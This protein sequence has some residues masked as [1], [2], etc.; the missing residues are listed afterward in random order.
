MARNYLVDVRIQPIHWVDLWLLVDE[1]T[2]PS[3]VEVFNV[4][5]WLARLGV[6][7]H[8]K[9][10]ELDWR[11]CVSTRRSHNAQ[12]K[13]HPRTRA[14]R[15]AEQGCGAPK[16][17]S[18]ERAARR[19]ESDLE[20]RRRTEGRTST[21][22]RSVSDPNAATAVFGESASNDKRATV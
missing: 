4:A 1:D 8:S 6:P 10:L 16:R 15:A 2:F 22:K 20:W 11:V 17:N 14:L 19:C 3:A 9:D 12:R 13:L 21:E 5:R 7:S 18:E